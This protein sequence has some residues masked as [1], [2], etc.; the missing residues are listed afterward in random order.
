MI[1]VA[2]QNKRLS[3]LLMFKCRMN[4]IKRETHRERKMRL[5]GVAIQSK[6]F[7]KL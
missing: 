6:R 3:K 5:N 2:I 7:K 4:Y 1:G